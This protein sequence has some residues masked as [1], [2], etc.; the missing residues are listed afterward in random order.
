MTEP[1][2]GTVEERISCYSYRISLLKMQIHSYMLSNSSKQPLKTVARENFQAYRLELEAW[3]TDWKE[4]VVPMIESDPVK[5]TNS[6]PVLESWAD[7]NYH[8]AALLLNQ[9]PPTKQTAEVLMNCHMIVRSCSAL[10]RHQ[11]K[12]LLPR[13]TAEYEQ[14]PSPIFPLNWTTAHLIFSIGLYLRL[15]GFQHGAT[16]DSEKRLGTARRCLTLLALLEGDPMMLSTG[17]SEILEGLLYEDEGYGGSRG[18]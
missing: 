15:W 18:V 12:S 17:F 10:A 8:H 4:E 14:H 1:M 5:V 2:S 3:L 7:L 13:G 11:Q 9:L 16:T 6:G